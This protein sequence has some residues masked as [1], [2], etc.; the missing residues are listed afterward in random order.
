[1][2][3]EKIKII[4][5]DNGP[6]FNINKIKDIYGKCPKGYQ[7]DHIIPLINKYVCG[8]HVENNLRVIKGKTNNHKKNIF[9]TGQNDKFYS[10]KKWLNRFNRI[11]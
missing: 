2:F 5:E 6:G 9:I 1:M 8:L 10:S 4:I 3:C 11:V 7:V